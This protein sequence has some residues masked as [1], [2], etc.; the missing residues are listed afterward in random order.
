MAFGDIGR[1]QRATN[2]A[3]AAPAPM[4][5]AGPPPAKVAAP[6]ASMAQKPVQGSPRTSPGPS[7]R[8]GSDAHLMEAWELALEAWVD[9][10]PQ[11]YVLEE[12]KVRAKLPNIVAR[13]P[14][15]NSAVQ[16]GQPDPWQLFV[17]ASKNADPV[18]LTLLKPQEGQIHF[19]YFWKGFGEVLHMAQACNDE[20]LTAELQTLR[21]R[22]L[23]RM[24]EQA[25]EAG[26]TAS[27]G[28][29]SSKA[30]FQEPPPRQRVGLPVWALV[31]EVHRAG[32]MSAHPRFWQ[33]CSETLGAQLEQNEV[34]LED[35]TSILLAWLHDS[36]LW[37]RQEEDVQDQPQMTTSLSFGS[38]WDGSFFGKS[39]APKDPGLPVYLHIYDVSREEGIQKLNRI[40]A[41]KD[42][43]LKFGGVFHAG[44]EVNGLEWSYGYTPS[45]TRYGVSCGQ[46]KTH[47]QH[48]FRQ[49]IKLNPTMFPAD[50]ISTLI[51][52]LVEEYP[53]PDY[54][55]LRR[56]CCHF[57]DDFCKRLGV[58]GIPGWVH[59]LARLGAGVDTILQSAPQGLKDLVVSE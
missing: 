41:H 19:L 37:T 56:N 45:E 53:G 32:S 46:P 36:Q 31:E 50:K 58:G 24:E 12:R 8:T 13:V 26:R 22:V 20:G 49:T 3:V 55:L 29:S 28:S 42:S 9:C 14:R 10:K 18:F 51:A 2:T 7:P 59:R 23:R 54:N 38:L 25:A 1:L 47:P 43:W 21:D 30:S 35:L 15:R 11:G 4:V 57:A 39:A 34:S 44:V 40:L 5:A 17:P 16:D 33:R 6:G 48:H 27:S 52:E